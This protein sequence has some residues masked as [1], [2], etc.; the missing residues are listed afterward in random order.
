MPAVL[1]IGYQRFLI[2]DAQAAKALT[3]LAGAILLDHKWSADGGDV[4]WPDERRNSEIG[5]EFIKA[6]QLRT[7]K[8]PDIDAESEEP[9][10]TP[11]PKRVLRL[12]NGGAQ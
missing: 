7:G 12:S 10:V 3:A 11:P 2:K 5:L 1:K 6:R 9:I 8:P 4:Y